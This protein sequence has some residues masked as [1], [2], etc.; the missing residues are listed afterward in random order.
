MN[1]TASPLAIEADGLVKKFGEHRAVDGVSLT[2]PTGSV[3]GV[4][5]PERRR[6]DHHRPHA[7]H[8]PSPRRR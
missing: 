7:R 2:V 1:H 8:S 6:Q 5:G 4:L 3:F